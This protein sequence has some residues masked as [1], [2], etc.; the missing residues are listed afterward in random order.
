M[1]SGPQ[2]EI[3]KRVAVNQ[4]AVMEFHNELSGLDDRQFEMGTWLEKDAERADHKCGTVGCIGGWYSAFYMQNLAELA[5]SM[6]SVAQHMKASW[7]IDFNDAMNLMKMY[8]RNTRFTMATFDYRVLP[9]LRKQAMLRVLETIV[10]YGQPMW[11]IALVD[12][13]GP[14]VAAGLSLGPN[15]IEH[16]PPS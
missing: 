8:D 16:T 14:E 10:E 1:K 9:E 13:L 7:G 4:Q 3:E 11:G 15:D 2:I 5:V 12:V 6:M